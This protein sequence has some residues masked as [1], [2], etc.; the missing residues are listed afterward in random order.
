MIVAYVSPKD[1]EKRNQLLEAAGDEPVTFRDPDTFTAA[2]ADPLDR[3]VYAAEDAANIRKVYEGLPNATVYSLDDS[4]LQV[5]DR[6]FAQR[7]Q[8][9]KAQRVGQPI[10]AA[11]VPNVHGPDLANPALDPGVPIVADNHLEGMKRV[12]AAPV[13]RE[14]SGRFSTRAQGVQGIQ[15]GRTDMAVQATGPILTDEEAAAGI[16]VAGPTE[17]LWRPNASAGLQHTAPEHAAVATLQKPVTEPPQTRPRSVP[18][19]RRA[20]TRDALTTRADAPDADGQ[21]AQEG[22]TPDGM[23]TGDVAEQAAARLRAAQD[24]DAETLPADALEVRDRAQ[25]TDTSTPAV[26]SQAPGTTQAE[27]QP[28]TPAPPTETSRAA[29]ASAAPTQ[30][31]ETPSAART[32]AASPPTPSEVT[33]KPATPEKPKA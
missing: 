15:G 30:T 20:D 10:D 7:R 11:A 4:P 6:S 28:A 24:T 21:T 27:G 8:Q 14:R 32:P 12:D 33:A 9:Q 29:R 26:A 19:Q 31:T 3:V 23:T 2:D 25:G 5:P 13:L 1:T 22:D 16:T 18:G 17:G